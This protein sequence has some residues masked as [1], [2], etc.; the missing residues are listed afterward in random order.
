MRKEPDRTPADGGKQPL[1]VEGGQVSDLLARLMTKPLV[2]LGFVF[3]FASFQMLRFGTVHDYLFLAIGACL[4]GTAIFG[5]GF[6]PVLDRGRRSWLLTFLALSGF[7]PYG[8]G[9]Y[10]VFYRGFWG[11]QGLFARFA[12]GGLLACALF[13]FLGYQVVNGM[14]L[15]T[16]LV[17]KASKKEIIFK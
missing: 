14:Y 10:L 3:I 9:C 6:I 8:F 12:V 13:V 15:L 2:S 17:D 5:H 4:S 7:I 11:L 16:E 1:V